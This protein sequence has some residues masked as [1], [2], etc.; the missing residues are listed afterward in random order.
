MVDGSG[1]VQRRDYLWVDGIDADRGMRERN[2]VDHRANPRVEF[3]AV[4]N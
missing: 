3:L 4:L 1:G 2:L